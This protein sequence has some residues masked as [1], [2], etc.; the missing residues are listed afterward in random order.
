MLFEADRQAIENYST[1][2]QRLR[3][4]PNA[5]VDNGIDLK[6]RPSKP[7]PIPEPEIEQELP[8]K[9]IGPTWYFL[10]SEAD[11]D[12][13]TILDVKRAIC[14][15]LGVSRNDLT[16]HC[17]SAQLVRPRHIAI[18]LCRVLTPRSFPYI[19][20]HF[21]GRDHTSAL[22]AFKKIEA[23]RQTDKDLDDLLNELTAALS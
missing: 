11:K 8:K 20:R 18:Y 1:I 2:H 16:T 7:A 12:E 3:N 17:R 15:R 9:P 22:H 4:P 10:K 6:R 14:K 19:G 5:K 23:L 13:I 21:G